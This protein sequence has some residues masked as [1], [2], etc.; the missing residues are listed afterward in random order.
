MLAPSR[1][2]RGRVYRLAACFGRLLADNQIAGGRK[3][4]SVLVLVYKQECH[5]P[6]RTPEKG[7]LKDLY[8]DRRQDVAVEMERN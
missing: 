8:R 5:K 2:G 1:G 7:P 6:A 3:D 4:R